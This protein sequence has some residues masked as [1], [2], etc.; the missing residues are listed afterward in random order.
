ML[1]AIVTAAS[2]CANRPPPRSRA[3]SAVSTVTA[4]AARVAGR[5]KT[6]SAPWPMPFIAQA[7]NGVSGGWSG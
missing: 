1:S 2:T 7:R 4:A 3:I 6:T 5:R